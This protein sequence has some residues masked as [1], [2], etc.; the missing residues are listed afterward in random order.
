LPFD[1]NTKR[2]RLLLL[3]KISPSLYLPA[4]DILL[5]QV[6]GLKN[7]VIINLQVVY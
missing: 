2:G 1:F 5:K 6:I 4:F 7:G 3:V